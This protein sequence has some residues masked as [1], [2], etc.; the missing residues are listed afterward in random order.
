[1]RGTRRRGAVMRD[2]KRE[3]LANFMLCKEP[4]ANKEHWLHIIAIEDEE[5]RYVTK[6]LGNHDNWIFTKESFTRIAKPSGYEY[7]WEREHGKKPLMFDSD[8]TEIENLPK[9]QRNIEDYRYEIDFY[10]KVINGTLFGDEDK[11]APNEE[12]WQE[13]E[14]SQQAKTDKSL[15]EYQLWRKEHGLEYD[16]NELNRCWQGYCAYRAKYGLRPVEPKSRL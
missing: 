8:L 4:P 13:T 14:D 7:I 2:N 6:I 16:I 5:Q 12:H 15:A 10:T 11:L 9:S 1:M 3:M